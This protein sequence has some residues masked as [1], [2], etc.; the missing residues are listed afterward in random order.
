MSDLPATEKI[1]GLGPGGWGWDNWLVW[2]ARVHVVPG[3]VPGTV[4]RSRMF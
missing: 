1:Q 4:G 3:S 2:F